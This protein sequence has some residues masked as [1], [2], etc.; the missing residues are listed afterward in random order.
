VGQYK[1]EVAAK[2][3]MNKVPGVKITPHTCMIQT[4]D[5]EFYKQFHIIIAGLD[6]IEA[7][8][9]LNSMVHSLVEFD[10]EEKPKPETQRPFI[11]GGTEGFKG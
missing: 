1:A 7:R 11:D 9:W 10:D 3:V 4:L 6:N 8:R 2:F 5:S